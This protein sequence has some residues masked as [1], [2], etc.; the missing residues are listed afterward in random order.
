MI[1][2]GKAIHEALDAKKIPNTWHTEPG[3]HEPKVWRH[4]LFLMAPLLFQAKA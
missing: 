1:T 3:M 4:S 2:V